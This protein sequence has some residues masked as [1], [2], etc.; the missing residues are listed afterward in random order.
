MLP[1]HHEEW[2]TSDYEHQRI[3]ELFKQ[4]RPYEGIQNDF[5]DYRIGERDKE[6]LTSAKPKD[7]R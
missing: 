2:P 3:L 1:G 4:D 5:T 7:R 6:H